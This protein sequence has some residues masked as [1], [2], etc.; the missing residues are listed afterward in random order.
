MNPGEVWRTTLDPSW[1]VV[2]LAD[3]LTAI[4]VVAP[5]T[6]A[7]KSGYTLLSPSEAEH[8]SPTGLAGIEVPLG[9]SPA[10]VIRVA[11]P[12]PNHIFCT[13][14]VSLTPES[15]TG[16]VCTLPPETFSQVELAVRLSG[17]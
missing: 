10:G 4:Q 8:A 12:H 6:E 13:W 5:A 11:L 3:D 15:L 7:Q 2:L 17:A 14:Q 16:Y 9:L 1:P